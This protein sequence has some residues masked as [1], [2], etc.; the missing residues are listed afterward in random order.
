MSKSNKIGNLFGLALVL[1]LLFS[2]RSYLG[3]H[4][5]ISAVCFF[6]F[7][8]LYFFTTII[9][10][11]GLF[12]YPV[13]FFGALGYFLSLYVLGLPP[14]TFPAFSVILV[15]CLF[16]AIR[17]LEK[18]DLRKYSI[19]LNRG[20]VITSLIFSIWILWEPRMYFT[21]KPL[22]PIITFLGNGLLYYL[23]SMDGF[24]RRRL[25]GALLYFTGAFLALLYWIKFIEMGYYGHFLLGFVGLGLYLGTSVHKTKGIDF[26]FPFYGVGFFVLLISFFYSGQAMAH[27]I[28]SLLISAIVYWGALFLL[29]KMRSSREL[30]RV[31]DRSLEPIFLFIINLAAGL[32]LLLFVVNKFTL[33][34][35]G[36][37]S[38]LL[39]SLLFFQIIL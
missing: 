34:I 7:T 37:V 28:V 21:S 30:T 9:S 33:T 1:I 35:P 20:M 22:I 16:I 12:L 24:K 11:E 2:T 4:P 8:T 10:K 32:S 25:Y 18:R 17:R 6:F 26:A 19:P 14:N 13:M 3:T 15:Y 23:R 36:I 31:L 5:L 29:Q 38:S 27:T 39:F